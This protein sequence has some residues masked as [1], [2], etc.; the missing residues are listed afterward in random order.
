MIKNIPTSSI[1]S[2]ARLSPDMSLGISEYRNILNSLLE[3]IIKL[4]S[5]LFAIH[6]VI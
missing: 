6:A 5:P 3:N 2:D 1:R 4:T